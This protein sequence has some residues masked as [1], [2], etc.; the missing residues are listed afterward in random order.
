MV[1]ALGNQVLSLNGSIVLV[2]GDQV[3]SSLLYVLDL[4][5]FDQQNFIQLLEILAHFVLCN[6]HVDGCLQTLDLVVD[7][8]IV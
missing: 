4:V 1:H 7:P 6:A 8:S 5:K 3:A 2:V